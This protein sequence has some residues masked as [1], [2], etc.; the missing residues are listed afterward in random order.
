[1]ILTCSKCGTQR[2]ATMEETFQRHEQLGASRIVAR[3]NGRCGG[4]STHLAGEDGREHLDNLE[5]T[6]RKKK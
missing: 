4:L 5:L 1:M 6:N 2:R 3:C